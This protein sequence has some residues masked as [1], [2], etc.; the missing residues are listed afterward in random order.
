MLTFIVWFVGLW[1]IGSG[2]RAFIRG[3]DEY[4]ADK[5]LQRQYKRKAAR[6]STASLD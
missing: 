4:Q 6:Y 3:L 1:L 2:I 5:E